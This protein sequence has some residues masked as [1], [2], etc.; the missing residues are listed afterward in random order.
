MSRTI[1]LPHLPCGLATTHAMAG[2]TVIVQQAGIYSSEDGGQFV[3]VLEG[4][5]REFSVFGFGPG[6]IDPSQVNHFLA[7]IRPDR[8]ATLYCNEL[9]IAA[10]VRNNRVSRDGLRAGE[11]IS[12]NDIGDVEEVEIRDTA[13]NRIEIPD[14]HG[15]CFILSH[16]WSKALIF[17]YDVFEPNSRRRT[18]RLPRVFGQVLARLMFQE[19][20]AASNAQ[21]SRL[22]AWGW[23]PFIGLTHDH[24]QQLLSW[25]TTDRYPT[26]LLEEICRAF[27]ANLEERIEF[28]W[29]RHDLMTQQIGFVTTSLERLRA[30][31]NVSCISVLYPRIE[32]IMRCLHVQENPGRRVDQDTMVTNLVENKHTHSLLLPERFAEYLHA[33]YFRGFNLSCG[34]LPLSRHSHAHG[35]SQAGDY[36]FIRAAVGFMIFDQLCHYLSD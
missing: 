13:N 9:Q 16:R 3:Q 34:E 10:R 24:R 18:E 33:V 30:G 15:F 25:A 5:C 6:R 21:W 36:N 8:H 32:G 29:K 22:F 26:S 4:I 14:D 12:G 23:F 7:V 2:E 27:T 19:M 20:Y 28:W 1:E 17:D 35:V 11:P 31:D